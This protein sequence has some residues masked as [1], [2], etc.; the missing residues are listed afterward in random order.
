[1]AA[2]LGVAIERVEECSGKAIAGRG[3]F[4]EPCVVRFGP[5]LFQ[6]QAMQT[7]PLHWWHEVK[8][9]VRLSTAAMILHD[10]EGKQ[11]KQRCSQKTTDHAFLG[12][13]VGLRCQK[14]AAAAGQHQ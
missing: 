13:W 7:L 6:N 14:K 9:F 10:D 5:I 12:L 4:F 11:R 1:M 2:S 8:P 3:G